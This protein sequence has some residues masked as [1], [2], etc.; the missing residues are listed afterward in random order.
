[1]SRAAD[2]MKFGARWPSR[3]IGQGMA[4]LGADGIYHPAMFNDRLLLG[5]TDRRVEAQNRVLSW[6]HLTSRGR[7]P[8]PRKSMSEA[9]LHIIRARN[10]VQNL[11]VQRRNAPAARLR[12]ALFS[13]YQR[14]SH[15]TADAINARRLAHSEPAGNPTDSNQSGT[16][17]ACASS[18][19]E[20]AFQLCV[21]LV[22]QIQRL[23]SRA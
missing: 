10:Q 5:L 22:T 7:K 8:Y 13:S 3:L 11:D 17:V 18:A 20:R 2:M 1:M 14:C 21:I 16:A 15:F 9:E 19:G 12:G 6:E 23:T 4:A